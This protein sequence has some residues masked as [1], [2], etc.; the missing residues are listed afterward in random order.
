MLAF[1]SFGLILVVIL[2]I[3]Y[4]GLLFYHYD[5][6]PNYALM[7]R[8]L[9]LSGEWDYDQQTCIGLNNAVTEPRT[10]P[11]SRP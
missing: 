1:L 7:D 6:D 9:A 11:P 8:C 4:E 2:F 5:M 3:A 10:N